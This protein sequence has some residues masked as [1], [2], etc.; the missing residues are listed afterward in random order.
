MKKSYIVVFIML[1]VPF[2]IIMLNNRRTNSVIEYN[3]IF[4]EKLSEYHFFEGPMLNLKPNTEAITVEIASTLFTDY[5]EKKENR[6]FT[7]R[8]KMI[9]KTNGLPQFPDGT[10]IAKTFYYGSR[11]KNNKIIK[12]V[13]ETRVLIKYKAKWNAAVYI[14]NELQNEAYLSQNG[15]TTPITFIDKNGKKRATNYVIPSRTDCI[16]CH[17]QD[18]EL[19]PIGLKIKN[20][21]MDINRNHE[22]V[23]QLEYLKQHNK[24][25]ILP[26]ENYCL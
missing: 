17:R 2:L 12:S 14:W 7:S 26:N 22:L 18:N 3:I 19:L 6:Y 4:K 10:I 25:Q 1:L 21:N 8:T 5:A 9:A 16:V 23:N 24:L 15:K 11:L 13:L 20:M